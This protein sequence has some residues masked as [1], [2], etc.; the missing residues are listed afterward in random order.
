[1]S[2]FRGGQYG[3]ESRE[4]VEAFQAAVEKLAEAALENTERL[5]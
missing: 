2:R 4:A 1:L 3:E 5:G